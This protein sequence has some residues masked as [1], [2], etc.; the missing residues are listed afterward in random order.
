VRR[1]KPF[2]VIW[3][4]QAGFSLVELLVA[5][6]LTTGLLAIT[7]RILATVEKQS[8]STNARNDTVD[9]VRLGM[10]QIDRQIRSA[11][12]LYVTNNPS[13]VT[14]TP[15]GRLIILTRFDNDN[16]V[17]QPRCV[18]WQAT[19]GVL[20]TRTWPVTWSTTG[21]ISAWQITAR[22]VPNG[23]RPFSLSN[24]DRLVTIRIGVAST[25]DTSLR[26][27]D[28]VTS[29]TL[30]NTKTTPASCSPIPAP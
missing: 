30:R 10:S 28:L 14:T 13:D 24:S 18:E 15:F 12:E 3:A 17:E 21:G 26:G 7:F 9:Q 25:A 4:A 29:Y 22:G 19:G 2:N 11:D 16:A 8:T 1:R 6:A 20:Q 23:Q 5:A 27:S